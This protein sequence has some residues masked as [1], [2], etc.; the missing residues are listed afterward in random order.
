MNLNR[1]D[2]KNQKTT[3]ATTKKQGNKTKKAEISKIELIN[4]IWTVSQ[5]SPHSIS[6]SDKNTF[7]G[8][9]C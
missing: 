1:G 8:S 5:I 7:H 2:K 6:Y 9:T 3:T 4:I